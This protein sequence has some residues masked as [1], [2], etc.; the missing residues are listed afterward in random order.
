M[1]FTAEISVSPLHMHDLFWNPLYMPR[2]P[3]SESQIE[4]YPAMVRF[5]NTKL[6]TSYGWSGFFITLP[7]PSSD[8]HL[9]VSLWENL[10]SSYWHT[11]TDF[12][13]VS[14]SSLSP[15]RFLCF[16][17]PSI[18]LSSPGA[19]L[20]FPAGRKLGPKVCNSQVSP[21]V[22][23]GGRRQFLVQSWCLKRRIIENN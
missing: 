19:D 7:K 8:D 2:F 15:T 13:C 12:I 16:P 3:V 9:L 22:W 20:P 21:G 11:K 23:D 18:I 10:S 14:L 6:F 5:P 1:G 4:F 17:R